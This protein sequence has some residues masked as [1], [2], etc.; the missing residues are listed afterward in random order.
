[1]TDALIA[2]W[3]TQSSKPRS[4]FSPAVFQIHPGSLNATTRKNQDCEMGC[5]QSVP[6]CG[7]PDLPISVLQTDHF[8]YFCRSRRDSHEAIPGIKKTSLWIIVG[9]SRTG[10]RCIMAWRLRIGRGRKRPPRSYGNVQRITYHDTPDD[11]PPRY[12]YC[13]VVYQPCWIVWLWTGCTRL[14]SKPGITC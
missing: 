7:K 4:T 12:D 11:H 3:E 1:M 5:D 8:P 13:S 9:N 2:D 14:L 10:S 6:A